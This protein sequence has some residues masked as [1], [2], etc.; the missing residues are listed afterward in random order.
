MRYAV[1]E[2]VTILPQTFDENSKFDEQWDD[3]ALY[4]LLGQ[5][6]D[7]IYVKAVE[8]RKRKLEGDGDPDNRRVKLNR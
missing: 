6:H 7:T 8:D 4:Q 2:S 3:S 1:P 5:M